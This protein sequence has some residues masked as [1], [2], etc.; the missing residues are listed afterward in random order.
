MYI[1]H[2]NEIKSVLMSNGSSLSF[3]ICNLFFFLLKNVMMFFNLLMQEILNYFNIKNIR[4]LNNST[5]A[6]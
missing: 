5:G 2:D 4:I 3:N 6:V 1:L